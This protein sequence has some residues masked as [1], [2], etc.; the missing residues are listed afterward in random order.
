MPRDPS[1][2]IIVPITR[3]KPKESAGLEH[4]SQIVGRVMR[5]LSRPKGPKAA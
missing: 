1:S 5:D 3:R 2:K 4:V